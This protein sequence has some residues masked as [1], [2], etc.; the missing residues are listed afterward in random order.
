MEIRKQ[1]KYNLDD[2]FNLPRFDIPSIQY[3]KEN[4]ENQGIKN[5]QAISQAVVLPNHRENQAFWSYMLEKNNQKL[6][7]IKDTS[8][9]EIG[10]CFPM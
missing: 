5:W 9:Y 6:K 1:S 7:S 8:I 10:S 4:K 2:L 3:S